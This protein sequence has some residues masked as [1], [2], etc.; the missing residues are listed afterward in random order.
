MSD[1]DPDLDGLEVFSPHEEKTAAYGYEMHSAATGEIIFGEKTGTDVGR[2]I[3]AD[4]DPAHRGFEMWSTANGNVY[5]CKGNIIASKNRPSVN[6]RVYWDGDLQDELLD[7]VKIDKWNGT[8]ANRMITLSDY[9]NAASCNSTKATPNLSA[10][11][12]GDWR[13]EIILWDSKTCSDLLVFTTIIPTEYKITTL[14]H[15]PVYR[16]GIAW[17]NVAY[18]QPPHLGYYLGDQDTENASFAK[19]G[20]GYLN[21]SIDLG[22]AISPISYSWK[23]AEDVK[24][25]GLPEGLNVV[26]DKKE[27]FFTIEGTPQAT[28]T[29]AYT[30]ESVGGLT[31]ATLSGSI[32]V[33]APVVLNEL[34]Y[35]SFDETTGTSAV[36]SVYGK[37]EAVGFVPTWINGIRQQALELPATPATRRMEQPSYDQLR[38][39]TGDFSVELWF[40]SNGGDGVDWYLFHKGSHAKNASTGATGK[41]VGL[42]YKNGNLTFGID[43]DVTKSNL[44]IPAT[45]YFNGE[46]NHVV[47]VRDGETKTLKMY[48]NG[49]FQG[50]VTDKTGDI[51]ES[52]LFVIGNCNVNFNTPFTGAIDE[53][54][55]YGGAMS[56][57]KAKERYE[58]NKPTAS[59][60][61]RYST[62]I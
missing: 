5:D 60:K 18:N 41:W 10:D 36:N 29:Y 35:F 50:E 54:H 61:K 52:E 56:A 13:E 57:A 22:E 23:N 25:A 47:C 32:K 34:A 17:Q 38:L 19:K 8:K 45:Q 24:I 30:I 4:I 6:F 33:K 15:D 43:D 46:W 14:M 3:A 48:I 39:G 2:G 16:M 7:G 42:Q 62:L 1:L 55:V 27:C 26:V 11:I 9:S 12:L 53:L 37:A 58:L 51:S 21:Q 20:I 49:V 28:G 59:R 40:R 44:D 31:V